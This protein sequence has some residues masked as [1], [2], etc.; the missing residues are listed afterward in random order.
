MK[1]KNNIV[2]L[3][4]VHQFLQLIDSLLVVY[5]DFELIFNVNTD[6]LPLVSKE[7]VS[8]D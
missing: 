5:T 3:T 4:I 2:L 1:H 8:I 7:I 6:T